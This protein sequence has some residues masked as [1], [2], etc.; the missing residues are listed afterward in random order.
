MNVICNISGLSKNF[1]SRRVLNE[2]NLSL[3]Q[4]KVYCVLGASGAGKT[5]L[6]KTIAGIH[7][8]DQGQIEFKFN[9]VANLPISYAFQ[10]NSIYPWLT[11]YENI[12]ICFLDK[13]NTQ[14]KINDYLMRVGFADWK[15][16]YPSELSGGMLQKLNVLRAFVNDSELVLMDEPFAQL[17]FFQRSDL[18]KFTLEI[19]ARSKNTILFVT[20]NIHEAL[21]MA[22]E[23]LIFSK[24]D[25][26]ILESISI[27]NKESDFELSDEYNKIY[28]H[29]SAVIENDQKIN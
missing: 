22:D 29:I 2:L 19:H 14:V 6:L 3:E 4:G 28:K 9:G 23:V 10:N 27:N 26:N 24:S 1:G 7:N 21:I 18:Q 16:N 5:T 13:V 11:V 12:E 25:K 8:Y 17:D 20:H 15:N